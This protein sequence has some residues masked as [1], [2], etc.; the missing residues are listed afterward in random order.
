MI[1]IKWLNV[2]TQDNAGQ[3]SLL[4]I[5]CGASLG[6]FRA[7]VFLQLHS[8]GGQVI[9]HAWPLLVLVS[10]PF[11]SQPFPPSGWVLVSISK[12]STEV[13]SVTVPSGCHSQGCH[14]YLHA[15]LWLP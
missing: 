12:L 13:L 5:V 9:L 6:L 4:L 10:K 15:H 8:F 1:I 7:A 14:G 3:R 11:C 2:I